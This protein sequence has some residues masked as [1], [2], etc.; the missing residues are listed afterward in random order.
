[1]NHA[2]LFRKIMCAR[3]Y[4]WPGPDEMKIKTDRIKYLSYNGLRVAADFGA[5]AD[6]E[7][8]GIRLTWPDDSTN[9]IDI[10]GG[11]FLETL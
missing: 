4:N 8:P 3:W 10:T 5:L 6:F 9:L 2:Q 11:S 7:P 1:M